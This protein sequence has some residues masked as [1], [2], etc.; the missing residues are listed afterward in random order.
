MISHLMKVRYCLAL[1]LIMLTCSAQAKKTVK[2]YYQNGELKFEGRYV[3][4]WKQDDFL[5]QLIMEGPAN[6][7]NYRKHNDLAELNLY[8]NLMPTKC[9]EGF[10]R[11][12]HP[13][14]QKF[15]EGNY[16]HGVPQGKFTY[17]YDNG[18]KSAE[19]SFV[20]GMADGNWQIWEKDGSSRAFFSYR[21]IPQD[22]L[23]KLYS[24]ILFLD[25]DRD[26]DAERSQASLFYYM[27]RRA[28]FDQ[29][30]SP[31][32]QAYND[33]FHAFKE[34]MENEL[35]KSADW[36]GKFIRNKDGKPFLEFYF[37]HNVPSGTWKHW[38]SGHLQ[39]ECTF[40]EGKLI[41]AKDYMKEENNQRFEKIQQELRDDSVRRAERRSNPSSV[42]SIDL[43]TAEPQAI[44]PG[45]VESTPGFPPAPQPPA[46][47]VFTYVEQ[48]PEFPGGIS[49]M[50]TFIE[51]NIRYPEKARK[52]NI[53][54][55]VIVQIVIK[56]D[57]HVDA[58]KIKIIRSL[59]YGTDEEVI[60]IIKSMPVWKPGKQNGRVVPVF[61][62]IP[63]TFKLQ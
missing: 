27:N 43:R 21:A 15:F 14:G 38:E 28:I 55:R 16:E 32:R 49:A 8:R 37:T 60:R 41:S 18:A 30:G 26:N 17:W 20:N 2:E 3:Y 1:A 54:G 56:E 57:G 13:G 23:A 9:Y 31:F 39:F 4:T 33:H 58:G 47:R 19:I 5:D 61:F 48:M 25:R 50:N 7:Y 36:D 22:T 34:C 11:F 29:I 46:D 52:N 24:D 62:S 45:V 6:D 51:K 35:F 42:G 12:Y 44:D 40:K 63:V 53:Q 59:G 10:C